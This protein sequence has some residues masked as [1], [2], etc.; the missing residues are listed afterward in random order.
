[1]RKPLALFLLATVVSLPAQAQSPESVL[2]E[3]QTRI[4]SLM[5]KFSPAGLDEHQAE[6]AKAGLVL[7][8]GV[9]SKG[10]AVTRLRMLLQQGSDDV[11]YL[12]TL[13]PP[14]SLPAVYSE[15]LALSSALLGSMAAS[16]TVTDQDLYHLRAVTADL[17][18]KAEHAR[19]SSTSAAAFQSVKVAVHTRKQDKEVGGYEVWFVPIAYE[20]NSSRN[21]RFD[22]YSSPT[23][24]SLVPGNYFLWARS[25][26]DGSTGQR[27][28]FVI[29]KGKSDHEIDIAAP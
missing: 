27:Q 7:A 12:K 14:Q 24:Q 23:T 26:A 25:V 3:L 29:G 1:M 13:T 4:Q 10:T 6:E 19:L 22:Q 15:N 8:K 11:T 28:V 17:H 5:A 21:R 20:G 9:S 2:D 16:N 18:T